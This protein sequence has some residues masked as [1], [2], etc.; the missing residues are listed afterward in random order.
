MI[1]HLSL[2][3][4]CF[5]I[6]ISIHGFSFLFFKFLSQYPTAVDFYSNASSFRFPTAI[7]LRQ[8]VVIPASY[9]DCS[10]TMHRHPGSTPR[11]TSSTRCHLSTPR[12]LYSPTC[13]FILF[14]G[15]WLLQQRVVIPLHGDCSSTMRRPPSFPMAVVFYSNAPSFHSFLGGC[16]S[17]QRVVIP[18]FHP[19]AW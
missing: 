3:R 11:L 13:R 9:G 14:H 2:P 5:L 17:W 1:R 7:V 15:G 6:C 12:R 16:L 19:A 18:V 4:S 8:C 10:S